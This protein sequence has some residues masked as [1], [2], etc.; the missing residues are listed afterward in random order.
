MRITGGS[1]KGKI[2]KTPKNGDII[3]PA[4]AQVREAVFSSLGD[5]SEQRFM[6][7]FAGTGSLG[8]EALSRGADFVYFVD[9]HPQAVALILENL[10]SLG[11]EKQAHLFKRRL[12][13]GLST[14]KISGRVDVVFCDPPYDKNLLNPTL[15]R[16]AEQNYI[17]PKTLLII[18]HTRR[19]VPENTAFDL[20][21]Q[22]KF[23]Q[24]LISY[25]KRHGN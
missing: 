17:D 11:F 8:F 14:I 13:H 1:A 21:K 2:I 19:E 20:I 4:L 24:T 22:K 12:P 9:D 5:V 6:D 3:R 10:K 23:G 16:L 7:V 18:E 15:A 25:L